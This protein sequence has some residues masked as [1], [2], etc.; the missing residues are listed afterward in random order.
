MYIKKGWL[1]LVVVL[2]VLIIPSVLCENETK[3]R[4]TADVLIQEGSH[5]DYNLR[6]ETARPI[7]L[8]EPNKTNTFKLFLTKNP[9]GIDIH[10]IQIT[11]KNPE[12]DS[13][14]KDSYIE[15][16]KGEEMHVVEVS[17]Y[18]KPGYV[19]GDYP[20]LIS[21]A[22][23]EFLESAYDI[24]TIIRIAKPSRLKTMLLSGCIAIII[25][26]V[27]IIS[28]QDR[29]DKVTVHKTLIRSSRISGW[30]SVPLMV[31]YFITGY[32]MTGRISWVEID[33]ATTVHTIICIPAIICMAI[34]VGVES[35]FSMRR[36]GW[37][38]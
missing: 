12:F 23:R 19:S 34:H 35:Y 29:S 8:V 9:E 30:I 5:K 7:I 27:L 16:F 24:P 33:L 36:W 11:I 21:V 1:V 37:I 31:A 13:L 15:T 25:L 26:Y 20:L 32:S 14:L 28:F 18:P 4:F 2:L 17:L 3:K 22:G 6:I 10:D 38:K